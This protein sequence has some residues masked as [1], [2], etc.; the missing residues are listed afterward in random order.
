MVYETETR[1]SHPGEPKCYIFMERNTKLE[2]SS[3]IC[4]PELLTSKKGDSNCNRFRSF[5][6]TICFTA[7]VLTPETISS[8]E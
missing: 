7:I 1:L 8:T 6:L 3:H 2:H 5:L 4:L